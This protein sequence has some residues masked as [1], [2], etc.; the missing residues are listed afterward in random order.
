MSDEGLFREIEEEMRRERLKKLW[1]R[2]GVYVLGAAVAIVVAVA[3]YRGWVYWYAK[4]AAEA[5]ERF[6]Q[7]ALLAE[8]GKTE[9]ALKAFSDIAANGPAAYAVLAELRL[10]A[11]KAAKGDK[12]GAVALY[13]A[14]SV[15]AGADEIFQDYARIQAA[16]LRLDTADRE[17]IRRRIGALAEPGKAWRHSA[18]ELL[19]MAAYKAGAYDVAERRFTEAL[20]D[21]AAP[22][23]LKRRMEMM[24]ALVAEATAGTKP[25][26]T[27]DKTT[28]PSAAKKPKGPDTT[29]PR[30]EG[31]N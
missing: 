31:T 25:S 6:Y 8:Q 17:E 27:Q 10:A 16:M 2:Y 14:I 29:K 18:R 5:G 19:G 3:G 11:A 1:E 24:L 9:E 30:N 12:A 21:P 23:N 7:A 15:K 13:D 20:G 4:Q 22:P 28:P 26:T